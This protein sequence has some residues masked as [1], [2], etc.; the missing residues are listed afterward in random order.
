MAIQITEYSY[1]SLNGEFVEF[2]NTGSTS[3]DMT[4]WSFDDNSRLAGSFSLSAF[5]T[6]KPGESVVITENT[7]V[8]AF[9][10]A[11]GLS[12]SVK[13]LGGSNLQQTT[14]DGQ[15]LQRPDEI[16]LYDK[17][18][19]L[20]DRLTYNDADVPIPPATTST[21]AG[22]RTQNVSAYTDPSNLGQNNASK[23]K[24][25][26]VGDIQGGKASIP[27]G[28]IA[29][30]DIGSPGSTLAGI[31]LSRYTRVGRYELPEVT[32]ING[33]LTAAQKAAAIANGSVLA[34]EASAVT[35]DWDTDTLFVVGDGGTSVVQVDK[36]GKLIDSMTLAKG[37]SPQGTTFYDPEGLAYV[38]NGKF[39]MTEERDRQIVSFTYAKDTT[40]TRAVTQAVKLGTFSNNI[41][42]EGITYDPLSNSYIIVKEE[43]PEGIFQ[44]TLDFAA[45][46]ASNG[47]P[48]TEN[49][50]NLFDP[51][52]LSLLDFADVYALSNVA[53]LSSK[54]DA[55]HLIVLSQESGKILNIDRSGKVYSSLTISADA[56]NAANPLDTL[57]VPNQS[58]E[59][60]TVDKN[61]ILYVVSENGG[62]DINHPELWVYAPTQ[63]SV[64]LVNQAPTA[65]LL[66]NA[67]NTIPDKTSTTTRFKLSDIAIIDDGL[68]TNNL[69]L[70]G[71][72]ASSFEI[73]ENARHQMPSKHLL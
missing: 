18:G 44:T 11:W 29:G 49:S 19:T 34:Q 71:T 20:V 28:T 53:A 60:V 70:T 21:L 2:T 33:S 67:I 31:D 61:G 39:V 52:K 43:D 51:F 59:G 37:S 9:K 15:A 24:L 50:T 42:L 3:V 57:S 35:Y 65:V 72:D 7:D 5:G 13:V 32:N 16:N 38:G 48:T 30:T 22:P 41:G 1:S 64:P 73:F 26:T 14:G 54:D 25:S 63:A 69:T 10:K 47:S 58:H 27:T 56:R 4:G 23:W 40:L 45:G 17:S 68:G 46:T 12:D 62:G 36:T 8:A 66:R 6:I 55:S